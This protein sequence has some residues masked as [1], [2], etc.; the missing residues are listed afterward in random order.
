MQKFIFTCLFFCFL[1]SI[2]AQNAEKNIFLDREFWQS[3]PT[4]E[5]IKSKIDE[6]HDPAEKDLFSFDGVSY[7]IID[8]APLESIKYMLSLEGNPVDKPTHGDVTYLLWSAYKGNIP[9]VEHLIELGSDIQFTTNRGTNI[10][11]MCGFG[12]QQ[13]IALYDLLIKNGVDIHY[14]NSSGNN[15]MLALAGSDAN[16]EN[17]FHYLNKKGLAWN[18]KDNAGNGFFHYAARAGNLQN[19]NLSL[20]QDIDFTGLN[21][22]GEN[23]MFYAAYGRKR[24]EVLLQTFN[25]LD[26]LGLDSDVVN[27]EGQTPLHHA[28]R[29]GSP[30]V[31]DFFLDRGVNVNQIDKNGNTAFMNAAKSKVENV[32][33]LFPLVKNPDHINHDGHSAL[34]NAV[35]Y[36][37]KEA[38]D[39]LITKDADISIIDNKGNDLLS[40]A[41]QS[42]SERRK[43]K[44]KYIIDAL[45]SMGLPSKMAYSEGNTL[46]HYA[47]EKNN[48]YLIE[49]AIELG[50][51][52]NHKND[53]GLTSLH[54]AAMKA[55]DHKIIDLLLEAGADKKIL[56]DYKESTY[57]LA[58][59][60]EILQANQIDISQLQ[61]ND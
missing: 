48:I 58:V 30:E 2:D 56:T 6:G 1:L 19:M 42:Y 36:A 33:K 21:S 12:G 43:E 22:K 7:G 45:I 39:F 51:D 29:R 35:S 4:V 57:E 23:A 32:E 3:E 40:L 28:V 34:S 31:I 60:N 26:S 53:L 46:A 54:F 24:S 41:F 59:E 52:L 55:D 5:I 38:F 16:D 27:W 10:L 17:I 49:K 44:I 25:Y 47:I 18:Y 61:L 50:A 13:D 15:I 8:K 9:L 20:L 37:N 11:L 14:T